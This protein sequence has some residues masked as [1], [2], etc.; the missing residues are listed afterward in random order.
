MWHAPE[1]ARYRLAYRPLETT[2]IECTILDFAKFSFLAHLRPFFVAKKNAL[3]WPLTGMEMVK[4]HRSI[5]LLVN[6]N[7]QKG[8]T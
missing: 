3:M 8:N 2:T 1:L 6:Q 4:R 7:P 5:D